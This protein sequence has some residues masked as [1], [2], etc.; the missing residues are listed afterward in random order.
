MTRIQKSA[1]SSWEAE[2]SMKQPNNQKQAAP[3]TPL[4]TTL[5]VERGLLLSTHKPQIR[6]R[7]PAN[8]GGVECPVARLLRTA[9]MDVATTMMA[10]LDR[11]R[12]AGRAPD[13][14]GAPALRRPRRRAGGAARADHG[15][16]RRRL[17]IPARPGRGARRPRGRARDAGEGGRRRRPPRRPVPLPDAPAAP[18]RRRRRGPRA[19]GR[20]R[21][22]LP[23]VL[24]GAEGRPALLDDD[25]GAAA[26]N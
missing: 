22:P 5:T 18:G 16:L 12:E 25:E 6:K 8:S 10:T 23:R 2:N 1:S 15:L 7:V 4:K 19:R 20:R 26:L 17:P 13:R 9:P 21:P 14:L 11:G 24:V 3:H